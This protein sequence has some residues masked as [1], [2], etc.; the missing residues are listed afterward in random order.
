MNT[1]EPPL[2]NLF[3]VMFKISSLLLVNDYHFSP[4]ART[5]DEDSLASQPDQHKE[6]MGAAAE[7]AAPLYW[8]IKWDV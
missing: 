3:V 2:S 6:V 5:G 1:G 4:L 8:D 7:K